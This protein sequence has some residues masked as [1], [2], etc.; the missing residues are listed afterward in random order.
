MNSIHIVAYIA[1]LV[2]LWYIL[3]VAMN[4][5]VRRIG[6]KNQ[7]LKVEISR[8]KINVADLQRELE[9]QTTDRRLHQLVAEQLFADQQIRNLISE[10]LVLELADKPKNTTPKSAAEME[11]N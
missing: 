9:K 1:L 6:H 8:L 3:H 10:Q 5:I 4:T 11:L 7:L 2:Y